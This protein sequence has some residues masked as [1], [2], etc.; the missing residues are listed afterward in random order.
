M[1]REYRTGISFKYMFIRNSGD[2][3]RKRNELRAVIV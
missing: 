2:K 1:G 3:K